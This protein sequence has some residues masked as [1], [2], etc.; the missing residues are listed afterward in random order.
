[1]TGPV[2][3][4]PNQR[5]FGAA[6]I[7]D[8]HHWNRS[9]LLEV[10]AATPPL[11]V[12]RAVE[13]LMVHHDGLRQRILLAGADRMRVRLAQRGDVTPF[14]AYDLTALEEPEQRRRIEELAVE[15]QAGLDPA[16]GP[17]VRCALFRLGGDRPDRL[18]I[19][20]HRLVADAASMGILVEDLHSAL[21]Q[22]VA[23]EAVTLPP[24]T[25]SWQSWVRRLVAY[26]ATPPVQ[27]QRGYWSDLV[28]T[29][30][31][32]LPVDRPTEPAADTAATERTVIVALSLSDTADLLAAPEALGC[33]IDEV[34][35]AA[36]GRALCGWS[37]ANR[38]LVDVERPGRV[39][40]FDEVDLSR[41]VGWVSRTHPVALTGDPH[42]SPE[43]DPEGGQ[44]DAAYGAG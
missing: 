33:G 28:A 36:L 18:A 6:A 11:L 1:M 24:K 41:T 12:E 39:S 14:A 27:S 42:D 4:A 10:P 40:L 15:I 22:L 23:G 30:S 29:P 31:G 21:A 34:L 20:A 35:L 44:G 8:P 37:G 19:V 3:V 25:T 38:H 5:W 2:P 43:G 7:T 13:H 16:V 32:R 26:A 9:V 17:L